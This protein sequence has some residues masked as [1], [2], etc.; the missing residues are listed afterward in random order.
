[1]RD[2]D[3]KLRLKKARRINKKGER[4]FSKSHYREERHGFNGFC[5]RI[6]NY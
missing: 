1:L 2:K 6:S 5:V 4:N 3:F